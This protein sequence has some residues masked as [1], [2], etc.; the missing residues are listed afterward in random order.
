[1]TDRIEPDTQ[2]A[3][4]LQFISDMDEVNYSRLERFKLP[5]DS[6]SKWKL[7]NLRLPELKLLLTQTFVPQIGRELFISDIVHRKVYQENEHIWELWD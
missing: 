4:K 5:H 1:M 6:V 3:V 7:W 2:S